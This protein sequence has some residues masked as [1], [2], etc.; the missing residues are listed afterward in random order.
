M[1]SSWAWAILARRLNGEP[2]L[3]HGKLIFFLLLSKL[4]SV[5]VCD[6]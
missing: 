3:L 6:K 5:G 2:G 4:L 1:D